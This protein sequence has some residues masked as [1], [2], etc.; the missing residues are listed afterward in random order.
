ML[1]YSSYLGGSGLSTDRGDDIAVDSSGNAYVC[2]QTYNSDFPT[3]NAF[4]PVFGGGQD[5]FVTKIGEV[6][7]PAEVS[8]VTWAAG[9]KSTLAWS[10]EPNTMTYRVY[11]GV[12]QDLRK[13]LDSRV[14]SCLRIST[15]ASTTGPV[16]DEVPAPR[17]FYWYLVRGE[18]SA[19]LGPA[20]N[21]TAGPRIQDSSGDCP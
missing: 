20:G 21:A 10:T 6:L 18:S 8:N 9:S 19:G 7:A 13:L 3:V 4:Q 2:G 5:G 15:S 16:L 12:P 17:T 11:R 14:D 1:V